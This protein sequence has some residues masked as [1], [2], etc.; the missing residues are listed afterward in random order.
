M[1]KNCCSI[2]NG[3][4]ALSASDNSSNEII[5]WWD[6]ASTVR[7]SILNRAGDYSRMLLRGFFSFMLVKVD[8][9]WLNFILLF[10]AMPFLIGTLY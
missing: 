6:L 8:L 2:P 5:T 3:M 10:L 9:T 1:H 7:Q 4:M